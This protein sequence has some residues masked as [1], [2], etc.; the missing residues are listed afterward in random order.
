MA[1]WST[2]SSSSPEFFVTT[3]EKNPTITILAL[4]L[5]A[6]EYLAEEMRK[7]ESVKV[8]KC[9]YLLF[10][11]PLTA[12]HHFTRLG[13]VDQLVGARE[14]DSDL[15]F[16]A[17][18]AVTRSDRQALADTKRLALGAKPHANGDIPRTPQH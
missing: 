15:G 2:Q 11:S 18:R 1:S 12:L 14:A 10:G 7:G 17:C 3:S 8:G 9:L 6:A 4:A 5:R 16:M 13:Q